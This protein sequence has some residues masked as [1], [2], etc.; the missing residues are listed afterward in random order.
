MQHLEVS[1]AVRRFFKSLGFKGLMCTGLHAG[2]SFLSGINETSI[3]VDIFLKNTQISDLMKIR[4]VEGVMFHAGGRIDGQINVTKLTVAFRNFAN[5]PN[6]VL[7]TGCIYV[8]CGPQCSL[9]GT[10]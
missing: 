3:H 8:S 10:N 9:R 5:V 6:N 4:P 2:C 7:P 1:C